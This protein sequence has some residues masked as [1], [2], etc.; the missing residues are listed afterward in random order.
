MATQNLTT[1]TFDAPVNYDAAALSGLNNGETI[2]LNGGHLLLDGDVRWGYNAAVFGNL[3]ISSTM[4]GTVQMDGTRVWEVPFTG[5]TGNVPAVAE[6]GSNGVTG[7]GF[8]GELLRVWATGELTPR[9]PGTEMPATGWIKLREK[10]GNASGQLTL[11]GGARVTA[12]TPDTRSLAMNPP[13][14]CTRT[15]SR[16][17][18]PLWS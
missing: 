5:G 3:T 11:P 14:C 4:G 10:T 9:N 16:G 6:A 2:N 15:A 17:S 1:G 7:S 13:A 12:S 18:D 8:T